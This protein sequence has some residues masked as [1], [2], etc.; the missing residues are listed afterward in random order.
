MPGFYNPGIFYIL[1][2]EIVKSQPER[3]RRRRRRSSALL[4]MTID[5]W[6]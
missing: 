6:I 4:T 5:I 1:N 3:S 2:D